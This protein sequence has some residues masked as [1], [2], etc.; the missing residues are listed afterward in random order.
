MKC[1]IYSNSTFI[2]EYLLSEVIDKEN[3]LSTGS[4]INIDKQSYC[5]GTIYIRWDESLVLE[6]S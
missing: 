6:V 1:E 4:I 5:V 3:I 2:G